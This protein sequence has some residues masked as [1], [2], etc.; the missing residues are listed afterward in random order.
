MNRLQS[1]SAVSELLRLQDGVISRRQAIASGM[2]PTDVARFVRRRLWSQVHPGVY[3]D[4]TGPPTWHQ[5][6]WA[7]VLAC[8][9]A[10]LD[11][12]SAM[13]AHEGPGRRGFDEGGP[14]EVVI[15]HSRRV[16]APNGVV[17]RRSRRYADAVQ[18]NLTPPRLRY[19]D[20]VL[21]LADRSRDDLAAIGL[22]ADACGSRRT[23]AS[24]LLAVAHTLPRLRRRRWLESILTDVAEGTCS[25]LEHG[26]LTRVE[27]PHGLPRGDRQ[28]MARD[29]D[30][31]RTFRDVRYSGERP[32]WCQLVELDGRLFHESLAA[33]RR[34]LN[35]DLDAAVAGEET[36]RLGFG[37][38]FADSC[39]TAYQISRLLQR[40]G[41]RGSGHACPSCPSELDWGDLAQAG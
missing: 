31:R 26:Y 14:I 18:S 3:V 2:T 41:W 16:R 5:R 22:I 17:I 32:R 6:A 33:R 20:A 39:R 28:V 11:G 24:R 21:D 34:D 35:R 12:H 1:N 10:A 23:T 9:P 7:A 29:S 25:V 27:R 37:Q 4:H 13:R 19:D 15:D 38:V 36:V 40:R 30:G 8:A